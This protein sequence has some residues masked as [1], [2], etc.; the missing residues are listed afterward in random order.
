MKKTLVIITACLVLSACSHT[1]ITED[2]IGYNETGKALVRVCKSSGIGANA[3]A[4][5]SSC[6]IELR[7][8]GKISNT[9]N[10]INVISNDDR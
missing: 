4:F 9:A 10:T 3:K 7:D 1:H 8:Y 2:I 6:L 5:G